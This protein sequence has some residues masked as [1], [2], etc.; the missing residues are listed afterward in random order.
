MQRHIGAVGLLLAL[1]WALTPPALAKVTITYAGSWGQVAGET[2]ASDADFV[3]TLLTRFE[4]ENPDIVVEWTNSNEYAQKL[5]VMTAAGTGPDVAYIFHPWVEPFAAQG[6]FLDLGPLIKRDTAALRPDDFFPG[7][8]ASNS[9]KGKIYALPT[10]MASSGTYFNKQIFDEAGVAYPDQSWTWNDLVAN[11]KK[12]ARVDANN[13]LTQFAFTPDGYSFNWSTGPLIWV[14]SNGADLIGED[15]TRFLLGSPRA[16]QALGYYYDV[17]FQQNIAVTPA[18]HGQASF[19]ERFFNGTVAIWDSPSWNNTYLANVKFAWDA[20]PTLKS[21]F[22]GQRAAFVHTRGHAIPVSSKHPEEAWRLV[23]F[24]SS[25]EV[26]AMWAQ[27]RGYQPT[28]AS[29]ARAWLQ[30]QPGGRRIN[31]QPFIDSVPVGR[32][33]PALIDPQKNQDFWSA[34]NSNWGRVMSRELSVSGFLD[35]VTP[36]VS[37]ILSRQTTDR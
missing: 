37:T 8:V 33:I 26:Q 20:A 7:T 27:Q 2:G 16:R 32:Y 4:A 19:W 34:I 25:P 17:I 24:L 5:L 23:K 28:R 22:T 11:G 21:P 36:L 18:D 13:K 6:I 14:W 1:I 35:T 29:A 31:L 30:F 12:L 15:E 3:K 9:Y 10:W